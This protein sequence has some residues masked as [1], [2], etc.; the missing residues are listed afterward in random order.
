[1]SAFDKHLHSWF[2]TILNCISIC[3]NYLL[4]VLHCIYEILAELRLTTY[5]RVVDTKGKH[6]SDAWWDVQYE[7]IFGRWGLDN[8]TTYNFPHVFQDVLI[9]AFFLSLL[10]AGLYFAFMLLI[11][12]LSFD[13]LVCNYFIWR[14]SKILVW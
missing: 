3:Y 12:F 11:T 4:N 14:F 5:V 10:L 8:P 13:V 9:Y 2:M 1:M 6:V 7:C